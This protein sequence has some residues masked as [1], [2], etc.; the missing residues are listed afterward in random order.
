VIRSPCVTAWLLC[1]LLAIPLRAPAAEP[2]ASPRPDAALA[3][4]VAPFQLAGSAAEGVADIAAHLAEAIRA[5]DVARV[6]GP[7]DL[8]GLDSAESEAEADRARRLAEAARLD[9]VVIGRVTQLGSSLS[10]DVRLRSGR[11]GAVA[12]TYVAEASQL[13][14][15]QP[16]VARLAE[17]VV[18]GARSLA[19]REPA[20]AARASA[21]SAATPAAPAPSAGAPAAAPT[22][23]GFGG[24]DGGEPLSIRSDELE[25]T[26]QGGARTLVF[27]HNVEVRRGDLRLRTEQLEA[28]YPAG[29]KEPRE[30]SAQ[31]GVTVT[32]GSRA[33]RCERASFEQAAQ[34]IVCQGNA[35]LRDGGDRIRGDRIVFA[36]QERRVSVEGDVQLH[37]EP[38]PTDAAAEAAEPSDALELA[39]PAADAPLAIR[40]DRL[41]A[42][43]RDGQREILLEGSVAVVRS[44][45]TL[46]S[47]RLE[48]LYPDQAHQPEQLVATGA[49][50]LTQGS[51]EA[52]CARAVY[53]RV[54]GRVEC[55]GEAELWDG[56]DR[57]HG[58]MIAFDLEAKT[59]VVTG[60]T[61]LL[62]RPEG[63]TPESALP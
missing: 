19:E 30:L 23:F 50:A 63:E 2:D 42:F 12:G 26:D 3:I 18:N 25:A 60:R 7:A 22:P 11:S 32:Q 56:E 24:L 62:L 21:P 9:A 4:G 47:D 17:Q 36:L 45:V 52:R 61:R 39:A 57:V 16:V 55:S 53:D 51:R 10:L 35:E 1:G 13:D 20:A 54:Q 6:V 41:E 29:A 44:D 37:L 31:G 27:R 34:R 14:A 33:A 48:A 46:R 8:A 43:D 59:V 15:L 40:A 38:R 49:V 58:E 5:L 28:F